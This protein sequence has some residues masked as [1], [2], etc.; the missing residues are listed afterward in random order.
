M[1]YLEPFWLSCN[2]FLC[3]IQKKKENEASI[4]GCRWTA[5]PEVARETRANA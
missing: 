2:E 5:K 1:I 4:I 3:I